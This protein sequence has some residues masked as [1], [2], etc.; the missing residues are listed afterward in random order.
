MLDTILAGLS[1]LG[2]WSYW[3]AVVGG[4]LISAAIGLLPGVGTPIVGADRAAEPL[5]RLAGKNAATAG[6][7]G[8]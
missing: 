7:M 1:H 6:A 4:V 2:T 3:G 5:M 8:L